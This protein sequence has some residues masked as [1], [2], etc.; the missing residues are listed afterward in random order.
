M[1]DNEGWTSWFFI[2]VVVGG[3]LWLFTGFQFDSWFKEKTE[4]VDYTLVCSVPYKDGQ[5][6]GSLRPGPE[7]RYRIN[8]A[9]NEIAILSDTTDRIRKLVNCTIFD[10]D[11]WSCPTVLSQTGVRFKD[12]FPTP[13]RAIGS[14][15]H[16]SGWKHR[17][18][19][20]IR[21]FD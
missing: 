12:G 7:T 15:K 16:V 13:S 10:A 5:C 21:I 11:N 14:T 19:R 4:L 20:V 18:H 2:L 9:N 6:S 17:F 1:D 3:G 8:R